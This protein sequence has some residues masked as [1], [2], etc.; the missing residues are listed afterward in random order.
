VSL[1]FS[2]KMVPKPKVLAPNLGA[3]DD[4]GACDQASGLTTIP[5][6]SVQR[7]LQRER[8]FALLAGFGLPGR[9]VSTDAAS[10]LIP[11]SD[12]GPGSRSAFDASLPAASPRMF[13]LGHIAYMTV[14]K[15]RKWLEIGYLRAFTVST[16]CRIPIKRLN[17]GVTC[18]SDAAPP[19]SNL[20]M[21]IS[22]RGIAHER[23]GQSAGLF[24]R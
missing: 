4:N 19:G 16:P 6:V 5:T 22:Q 18:A 11:A 17:H 13:I 10:V 24:T 1:A 8:G 14:S 21:P 7:I 9:C 23:S 20:V 3:S 12:S 2:S 15:A